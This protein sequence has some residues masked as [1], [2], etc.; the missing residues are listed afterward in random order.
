MVVINVSQCYNSIRDLQVRTYKNEFLAVLK[1]S[2]SVLLLSEQ[3]K[4]KSRHTLSMSGRNNHKNVFLVGGLGVE[5][6][7]CG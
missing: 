3:T 1:G 2:F 5:E 6:S 4:N 7:H